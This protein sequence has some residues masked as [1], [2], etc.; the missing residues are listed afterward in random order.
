[1]RLPTKTTFV[2]FASGLA[3]GAVFFSLV[4]SAW[5][6]PTATAP[7]SN[8]AAPLNISSVNQT[9]NGNIGVNGLA[10]FGNT[11]LGGSAGSNAYLNFGATAGSGG[12]GIWDSG[13]VLNFKNS[14]GSWQTI[15]QTVA[16]LVGSA[17]LW[18][19]GS[20]GAISYNGGNVGIN[21]ANPSVPLDVQGIGR[22]VSPNGGSTGG[23]IIEDT[24]GNP[25]ANYLQFVNNADNVQYG[26][27]RGL[28]TGGV[29]LSP[30][31]GIGTASPSQAL[32]VNGNIY[33]S[34]G[35]YAGGNVQ[36]Y[37]CPVW[38]ST[39]GGAWASYGCI[40]QITTQSTCTNYWYSGG[41]QSVSQ[42]C[43]PIN[44]YVN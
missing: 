37:V 40:G 8:V 21:T 20:G 3:I 29:E 1:M 13:G 26:F 33:A 9:K 2:A 42:S 4:A 5:S 35:V 16:T 30:N 15:Q 22:F 25:N 38:I 36:V 34:G 43:T 44:L 28:S 19:S 17:G 12:Y 6:G 7:G 41:V 14:G 11:L 39:G 18:T 23:V 31:V 10:V 27:V 24:V 32:Q